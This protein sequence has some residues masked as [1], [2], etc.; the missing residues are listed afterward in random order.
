M[1]LLV[2]ATTIEVSP[3]LSALA[4][5][6]LPE[7]AVATSVET[8]PMI[9]LEK[10]FNFEPLPLVSTRAVSRASRKT[11][12][13][14]T[15]PSRVVAAFS[16]SWTNSA[17]TQTHANIS[18]FAER[19]IRNEQTLNDQ[20]FDAPTSKALRAEYESRV[21][22]DQSRC[23]AGLV[24]SYDEKTRFMEMKNYAQRAVNT[25]YK[26]RMQLEGRR[27]KKVAD[28]APEAIKTP[29]GAVAVAAAFYNGKSMN[30][31]VADGLRI[32]SRASIK[33]RNASFSMNVYDTGLSTGFAYN[34]DDNLSAQLAQQISS[35]ISA[36]VNSAQ[37]GS[38]SLVYSVSF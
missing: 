35:E 33:N 27:M 37:N 29:V 38:A 24:E 26:V 36:V 28:D 31:K 16:P 8:A 6:S 5:P 10:N 12:R 13:I 18:Y 25:L 3:S 32:A 23:N 22:T 21:L 19:S 4:S 30:F 7:S 20:L 14:R 17:H 1:S 11:V 9:P 34:R 15:L 2:C